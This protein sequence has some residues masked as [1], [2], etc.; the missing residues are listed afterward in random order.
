M[1]CDPIASLIA[2]AVA[3]AHNKTMGKAYVTG[4]PTVMLEIARHLE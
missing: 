3:I 4:K 2:V 1:R